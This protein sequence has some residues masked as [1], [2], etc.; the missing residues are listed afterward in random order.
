VIRSLVMAAVTLGC[1][2][3][4]PITPLTED[5]SSPAQQAKQAKP[6]RTVV[7]EVELFF[8]GEQPFARRGCPGPRC[9]EWAVGDV[10]R[11]E[12]VFSPDKRRFAYL[13]QKSAAMRILV[14]NLAGDPI[15]EFAAYRNRPEEL[16][17]IDNRRI[18]YLTQAENRLMYV[19]HDAETGE[20]LA[21]RS[22][23][24]P[25]WGPERRHVAFV[26]GAADKQALVV[27][28]R[29][30]WPRRGVTKFRGAPVWSP[31]GHGL[32]FV[33]DGGFGPR[34]VVLVEYPDASGDLTWP[35]P[36]D[37]LAPGL[38][39]FWA[40][41]SKVVIGESAL[42]PRFAADWERLR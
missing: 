3:A 34:L 42:R 11:G 25:V 28:G 36:R 10:T 18:G 21:A 38:R 1:A 2:T 22:G 20:V 29:N 7:P 16:T 14:R 24:E 8:K 31:D 32:A 6:V 23:G 39:V 37:A 13:R 33:E 15:N 30:V 27:D 41:D 40:G 17:W 35:I 26:T 4:V 9:E 19:V 12:M 5:S